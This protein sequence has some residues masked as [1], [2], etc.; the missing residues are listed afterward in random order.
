MKTPPDPFQ[1][2]PPDP[3]SGRDRASAD[4]RLD[5][6]VAHRLE[7][8]LSGAISKATVRRLIMAGAVRVDGRPMRRPGMLLAP[9]ARLD[10][11]F[12]PAR[13][14]DDASR[15]RASMTVSAADV[16]FDDGC[17]LAVAK[18]PGI[19]I[20]PTADPARDDF[21]TAVR[22]WLASAR[23]SLHRAEDG[24]PYLA[25]H[26]R[27]D[28]DTSGVVLFNTDRAVNAR[29]T[30]LFAAREVQKVYR[31]L[32]GPASGRCPDRW[33]MESRL[34]PVGAGRRARVRSVRKGGQ[35]AATS[36]T[37]LERLAAGLLVEALP[38]SGRKHQI[39]AH[40]AE[41]RLPI[42]GDPRY[43]G[44]RRIAGVEIPRVMLHAARLSLPHPATGR[45]VSIDCPYPA[46]FAAVLRLIRRPL[47]L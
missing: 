38:E 1:E 18:P 11:A 7:T 46:D 19:P 27:L 45:P 40:L 26:H 23:P 5:R 31:A 15:R 28:V 43:G 17:L 4:E 16:L 41:A 3:G 24:L 20:H 9:G 32:T 22:R 25:L 8:A 39:R 34:A 14:E 44:A 12:D 2:T 6:A 13:L 37:V 29:L 10:V 30:E 36:F 35:V 47:R 33:R 42:L 21:Y